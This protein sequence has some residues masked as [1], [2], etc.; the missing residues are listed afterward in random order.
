[1]T[2]PHSSIAMETYCSSVAVA[3]ASSSSSALSPSSSLES[4]GSSS[5]IITLFK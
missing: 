3:L 5:G 4:D 1:M 2:A